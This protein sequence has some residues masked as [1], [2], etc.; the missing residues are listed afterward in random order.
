MW[1]KKFVYVLDYLK[2]FTAMPKN[3]PRTHSPQQNKN[4]VLTTAAYF[5][6]RKVSEVSIFVY[7]KGCFRTKAEKVNCTS[8]FCIFELV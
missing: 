4:A 1:N 3:N 6:V 7:Q 2:I 5:R 8:E